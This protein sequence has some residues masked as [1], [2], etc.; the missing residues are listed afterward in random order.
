MDLMS[1]LVYLGINQ[2]HIPKIGLSLRCLN[3][4]QKSQERPMTT[5]R[6]LVA[7]L[8]SK[9]RMETILGG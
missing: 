7:I 8:I 6:L 4:A 9:D 3:A 5:L 2:G 1:A